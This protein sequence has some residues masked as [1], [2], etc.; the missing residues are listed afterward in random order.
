[1]KH[2]KTV[3][4]P[5]CNEILAINKNNGEFELSSVNKKSEVELSQLLQEFNIEFG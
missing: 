2:V 4:C 5:C 1:M 3:T